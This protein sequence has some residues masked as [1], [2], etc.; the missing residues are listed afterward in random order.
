[1]LLW[2]D[3]SWLRKSWL[4]RIRTYQRGSNNQSPFPVHN[5]EYRRSWVAAIPSIRTLQAPQ[6]CIKSGSTSSVAFTIDDILTCQKDSLPSFFRAYMLA[7]STEHRRIGRTLRFRRWPACYR[8]RPSCARVGSRTKSPWPSGWS[9]GSSSSIWSR[10]N[11]WE[12]PLWASNPCAPAFH[13]TGT[14][15]LRCQDLQI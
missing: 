9:S 14:P 2:A 12:R 3:W 1:M 4:T 15:C 8:L 6:T 5:V 11:R 10:S 13:S 7:S